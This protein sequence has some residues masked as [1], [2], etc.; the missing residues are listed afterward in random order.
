M[1][2]CTGSLP[3]P[4]YTF[5]FATWIALYPEFAACSSVQGAAWF[6]R[7]GLYC[8]NNV[9]NPPY[10]DGILDQL[11]YMLTSHIGW[12]SAPR[13]ADGYPASSGIAPAPIVGRVN[14]ASEGSVSVGSEWSGSGSPSEAW[15]LQT[16]YGAAF[17]QATAGYRTFRYS[18]L[19]T[20]VP[21]TA[22]PYVPSAMRRRRY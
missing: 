13:G 9:R 8:A 4:A 20:V 2:A 15:F 7:A 22:F 11:L 19:P 1:T 17:W 14:S 12:L 10:C 6:A 3:T 18:P 16:P 21:G 5:D